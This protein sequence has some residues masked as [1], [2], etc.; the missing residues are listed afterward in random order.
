MRQGHIPANW[1]VFHANAGFFL[2]K[3]LGG[4]FFA[5]IGV[6]S[7]IALLAD[8]SM[9]YV[10]WCT[11]GS[12]EVDS[13]QFALARALDFAIALALLIGGLWQARN[14]AQLSRLQEQIL[15]L[16]PDGFVVNVTEPIPHAFAE[17]LSI[18]AR[19][20]KSKATFSIQQG[21]PVRKVSLELDNRFGN[22]RQIATA[23]VAAYNTWKK[24]Q[25][26]TGQSS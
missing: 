23:V 14:L 4:I 10:P 2:K 21:Q 18:S 25:Q 7:F 5:L 20:E 11:T 16:T 24:A 9:A 13:G 8:P 1:R 3:T 22:T 17:M 15:V 26:N 12:T 6:V 19:W